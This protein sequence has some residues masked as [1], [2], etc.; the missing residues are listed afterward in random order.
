M[1]NR[2]LSYDINQLQGPKSSHVLATIAARSGKLTSA[3]LPFSLPCVYVE[4]CPWD[5]SRVGYARVD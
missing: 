3:G 2:V 4:I 5:R 1:A